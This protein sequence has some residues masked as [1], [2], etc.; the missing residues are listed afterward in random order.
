M[1]APSEHCTLA[2]VS[3]KEIVRVATQV[4]VSNMPGYRAAFACA[5]PAE[6]GKLA[7][8]QGMPHLVLVDLELPD[9]AAFALLTHLCD[10]HKGTRTLCLA[11]PALREVHRRAFAAGTG[12]VLS[13]AV[14]HFTLHRALDDVRQRD[15]HH[16]E[17]SRE[18]LIANRGADKSEPNPLDALSGRQKDILREMMKPE[19]M[20]AAR[21]AEV[22]D[23]K[24]DTVRQ[25]RKEIF[26]RL[27]VNSAHE[28]VALAR[29]W[30][31]K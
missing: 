26:R 20:T 2:V 23:M 15:F 24:P 21:I 17:L 8:A 22:L 11:Q 3:E 13:F 27:G 12:A 1:D 18:C 9:H 6:F 10:K 7:A 30:G 29:R 14:S 31:F 16:N 19:K 4:L 28:A 5:S 25:H